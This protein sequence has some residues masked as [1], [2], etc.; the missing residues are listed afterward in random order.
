MGIFKKVFRRRAGR[1]RG[2]GRAVECRKGVLR[3]EQAQGSEFLWGG[4][5]IGAEDPKSS[6]IGIQY[7]FYKLLRA[8][9]KLNDTENVDARVQE[10]S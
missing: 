6:Q 9:E 5:V 3:E 8:K 7:S 2:R 4:I 1:L 10:C